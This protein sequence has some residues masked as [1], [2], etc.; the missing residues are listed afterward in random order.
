MVFVA[1]EVV[2]DL[3]RPEWHL[4]CVLILNSIIS[5]NQILC[6]EHLTTVV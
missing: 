5:L 3:F 1:G 6:E 2:E 4:L